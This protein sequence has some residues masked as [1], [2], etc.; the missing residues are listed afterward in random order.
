[1]LAIIV[2]FVVK[3]G[4]EQRF[5]ERVRRQAADTLALEPECRQFDVCQD[6]SDP[7]QVLLYE[8][9]ADSEAFARHLTMPHF[10]AFDADTRNWIETKAV[11]RWQR[12]DV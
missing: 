4:E 7:R 11:E 8:L 12:H 2:R 6:A 3:N 9:Y 1:M 10:V 5:V